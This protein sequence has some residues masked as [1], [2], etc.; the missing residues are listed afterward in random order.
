[1]K[2]IL[3]NVADYR[4]SNKSKFDFEK[5]TEDP[6]NIRANFENYIQGFSLNIRE[7]IEYFEFDN[8]IKKL[9][10]NDLLFL[11][12]K[13]LNNIDLHP[14]VVTNQEMGYIFEELIRRFSENAKA[15]DH[16][17]PGEVIELMV[18]LIFNG[19]EEELTTLGSILQ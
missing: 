13:E 1:M 17:T 5:L 15:G 2:I 9:D 11:V 7:I 3:N 10:D 16:Y 4:F 6:D 18:N 12:I 8:E 14:D 19:L